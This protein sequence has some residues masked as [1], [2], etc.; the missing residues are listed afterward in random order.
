MRKH[1]AKMLKDRRDYLQLFRAAAEMHVED[2]VHL[3]QNM[4]LHVYIYVSVCTQ[5]VPLIFRMKLRNFKKSNMQQSSFPRT[6]TRLDDFLYRG[7]VQLLIGAEHKGD[8]ALCF[9]ANPSMCCLQL[10][11]EVTHNSGYL[12]HHSMSL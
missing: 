1:S 12:S 6:I 10:R 2:N 8:L 5:T 4:S 3:R 7:F 11:I 9:S